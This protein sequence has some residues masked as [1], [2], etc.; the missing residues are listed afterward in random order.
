MGI[1]IGPEAP[2]Q[3]LVYGLGNAAHGDGSGGLV[4]Y[5]PAQVFAG[6]QELVQTVDQVGRTAAVGIGIPPDA[7]DGQSIDQSSNHALELG[8]QGNGG[9]GAF[10]ARFPALLQK[11]AEHVQI[12]IFGFLEKLRVDLPLFRFTASL[13]LDGIDVAG[14]RGRRE[15]VPEDGMSS[16]CQL[17][18]FIEDDIVTVHKDSLAVCLLIFAR[19]EE[20]IV[21][22]DLEIVSALAVHRLHELSVL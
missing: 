4:E 19:G 15:F 5:K 3:I 13:I 11:N 16:L 10:T 9:I 17:M 7:D 1:G 2:V 22:R 20:E 18:G 21:V 6:V 14:N 12:Q 8:R